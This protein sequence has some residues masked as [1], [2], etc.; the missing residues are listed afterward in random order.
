MDRPADNECFLFFFGKFLG[1]K[2][3]ILSQCVDEVD[4]CEMGNWKGNLSCFRKWTGKRSQRAESIIIY[5][6]V[7]TLKKVYLL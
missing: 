7:F 3:C 5:L 1:T 6:S 2:I 4:I